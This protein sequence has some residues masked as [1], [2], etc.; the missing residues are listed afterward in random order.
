MSALCWC[1]RLQK[2]GLTDGLEEGG[3]T[4][5]PSGSRPVLL[6]D[7][8]GVLNAISRVPDTSV[9]PKELWRGHRV[10]DLDGNTWPILAAQPVLD[11]LSAVHEQGLAE[12]R[13]HTTWR[14]SAKLRL[15]PVLGLPDWPVA[16]SPTSLPTQRDAAGRWWKTATAHHVVH[17]EGRR[18]I[19]IDDDI[20]F[21]KTWP[22][23]EIHAVLT[24]DVL[25]ISPN[26]VVGL[27]RA[28]L[29]RVDGFLGVDVSSSVLPTTEGPATSRT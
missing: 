14:S 21:E 23:S 17:Q 4:T 9:W 18:L 27:D 26:S 8:D 2:S 19:W 20:A 3:M 7:V 25:A 29:F 13:W 5:S 16:E 12:I 22:N 15:A 11:Y 6:L 28:D 1:A 24:S 10:T